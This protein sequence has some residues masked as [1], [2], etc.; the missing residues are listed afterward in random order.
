MAKGSAGL[1]K[2]RAVARAAG[3]SI[4]TVSKVLNGRPDV[5]P[6]TRMRVA[7]LLGR[8]GYPVV[9]GRG[10]RR[11]GAAG[12]GNLVE[13]V[14]SRLDDAVT[15]KLLRA[16]CLEAY[17]RG[18]GVIVSDVEPVR[19]RAGSC[20]PRKWLDAMDARGAAAVISLLL[21]FSDAQL[22]YFD[23]RGVAACTVG[24]GEPRRGERAVR[25]DERDRGRVAVRHLLDLGHVRIALVAGPERLPAHT[26]LVQGWRETLFE[27]GVRAPREYLVRVSGLGDGRRAALEL[28]ALPT[29]PT[30]VVF[31]DDHTNYAGGA[32]ITA[33]GLRIPHDISVLCCTVPGAGSKVPDS[34]V[35]TL[36]QPW[37]E[38][39]RA[40]M[41][42]VS[43]DDPGVRVIAVP[44][45][46][47]ERDSTAA[48]RLPG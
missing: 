8:A 18:V 23:V 5:A 48:P 37:D 22:A 39:A 33:T 24:A 31:A 45:R 7:D 41:D 27:A 29:P 34:Q 9:G 3:V 32:A 12:A 19:R 2:L 16:V 30:A 44:P 36:V 1:P 47:V 21:E 43:G 38:M 46:I 10:A 20:P 40:A 11:A 17:V 26:R 4:S 35:T 25:V 14:A 13:V 6:Q 15:S 28:L 42:L